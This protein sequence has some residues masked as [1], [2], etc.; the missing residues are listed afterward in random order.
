MSAKVISRANQSGIRRIQEMAL[1]RSS[2]SDE[3]LMVVRGV[4]RCTFSVT[5]YHRVEEIAKKG[6]TNCNKIP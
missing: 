3:T 1:E 5:E 6:L 4:F 2:V